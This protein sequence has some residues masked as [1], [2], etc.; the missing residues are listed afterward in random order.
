MN[1]S[2]SIGAL[3]AA[4]AKAQGQ[5]KGAM[6]D[7]ENPFFHSKYAD[8]SAVWEACRKPLSDNGLS[9]VQT[10]DFELSV[11]T[12]FL[13]TTLLHSSGEWIG[14]EIPVKPV[15]DDPQ[16]LGS[17]MTYARRYGLA[18]IV[19]VA[20]EDDDGNAASGKPAV[21]TKA[22][23][24]YVAKEKIAAMQHPPV[25][26]KL[27]ALKSEMEARKAEP[28]PELKDGEQV[29]RGVLSH[30][31]AEMP[32]KEKKPY[33]SIEVGPHKINVFD[34]VMFTAPA[35][36]QSPLHKFLGKQ[37][38]VIINKKGKYLNFVAMSAADIQVGKEP[39][40]PFVMDGPQPTDEDI[41]F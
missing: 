27:D 1:K 26:E 23:A 9:V 37:V 29:I 36:E 3:A 33:V 28:T 25:G 16:G 10:G 11:G 35:G 19:G 6:K 39:E 30:I 41:P 2:E 13:H 12:F 38:N 22:A 5:I 14:G 15:K 31:S 32:T 34:K 4:L 18:A 7:S 20:P 8:L 40:D 17:A 21:G 24:D